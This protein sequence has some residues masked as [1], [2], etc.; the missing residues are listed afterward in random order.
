MGWQWGVEAKM[1]YGQC[2]LSRPASDVK[3]DDRRQRQCDSVSCPGSQLTFSLLLRNRSSLRPSPYFG[4]FFE[5]R[6]IFTL[7]LDQL[8]AGSEKGAEGR[9]TR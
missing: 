9:L 4:S 5:Q 7:F 8:R 2:L 6:H 3:E 1:I